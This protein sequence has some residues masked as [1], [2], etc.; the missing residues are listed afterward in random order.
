M[1]RNTLQRQPPH[2]LGNGRRHNAA[3]RLA[4]RGALVRA[5]I[6][7]L[8]IDALLGAIANRM[9]QMVQNDGAAT[10]RRHEPIVRR[11]GAVAARQIGETHQIE[12]RLEP[13]ERVMAAGAVN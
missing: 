8:E 5:A 1:A 3:L 7:E 9:A 6:D 2:R 11:I 12:R 4:L 13:C 10:H